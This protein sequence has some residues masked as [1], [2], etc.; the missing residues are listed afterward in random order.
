MLRVSQWLIE[1]GKGLVE[2]GDHFEMQR[3]QFDALGVRSEPQKEKGEYTDAVVD[4]LIA[5]RAESSD[6][7]WLRAGGRRDQECVRYG[8]TR[9]QVAGILAAGTKREKKNGNSSVVTTP[10]V[11]V[12]PETPPAPVQKTDEKNVHNIFDPNDWDEYPLEKGGV[13]DKIP[14]EVIR[15]AIEADKILVILVHKS[16]HE[17]N[18][19]WNEMRTKL[20]CTR[21][22]TRQQ[23]AAIIAE[24]TKQE[25]K[26]F[27]VQ[28]AHA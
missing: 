22:L 6:E 10:T 18:R 26:T 5:S 19:N 1:F 28:A 2:L 16:A 9:E 7:D 3:A 27:A 23:V 14:T 4:A 21:R 13:R 11:M 15:T 12:Q 24:H 8:M 25:Q 17:H 20:C